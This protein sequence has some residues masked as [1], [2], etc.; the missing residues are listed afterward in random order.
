VKLL[1]DAQDEL[2][3]GELEEWKVFKEGVVD[4]MSEHSNKDVCGW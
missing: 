3:I 1:T 2:E 4:A